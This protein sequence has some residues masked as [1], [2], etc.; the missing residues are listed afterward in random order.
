MDAQAGAVHFVLKTPLAF[1]QGSPAGI[2]RAVFAT[3]CFWGTEKGFWRLPRGIYSTA[4]GY[5]GGPASGGKPAYN[6]VCSGATGHAEA[7]QVLYDPSK[8]SYSDLL[9]LFWESHDPTQGNCQGND[10]G[11]QYRSGIYYSDED[12]KTLATASKDAYQEALRVAKKGRGQSVT[13][14]IA[15]LQEFFLAEDYHQQYLAR[16]GN[17]QY[18]SAEPQAVSLPPYEKWAPSGLSADHAPK[19]PESY[20]AKHAPKPGCV[21]HCPNEPIQWSD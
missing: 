10:R 2:R 11:T 17:R 16:P 19:L 6:A 9:R 13:T 5:C 7:V 14:E 15:P 8:I 12:Q 18:C 1:Q 4:V 3:G 20:W 21:L